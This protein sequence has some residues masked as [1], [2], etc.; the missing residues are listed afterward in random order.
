MFPGED[1]QLPGVPRAPDPA[2][3]R[4]VP[5]DAKP[6]PNVN[7]CC[8]AFVDGWRRRCGRCGWP[9]GA[10][11]DEFVDREHVK[12]DDE[13]RRRHRSQENTAHGAPRR[14]R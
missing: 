13:D 9:Y 6:G 8:D 5:D 10:H 12:A 2:N 7:P 11:V 4:L 1:S 14:P 3:A